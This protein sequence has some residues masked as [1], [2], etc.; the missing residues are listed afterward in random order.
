MELIANRP[1]VDVMLGRV[2]AGEVFT[3]PSPRKRRDLIARGIARAL[4]YE[5]KVIRPEVK[6]AAALPFRDVLA[7]DPEPPALAALVAAVRAVSDVPLDG[8]SGRVERGGCV[9]PN[10]S[11]GEI[12]EAVRE[13]RD[14]ID[15][16]RRMRSG[17]RRGSRSL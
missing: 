1:F 7:A 5:T 12:A 4:T 10:P 15:E 17:T 11:R 6:P 2:V 16:E 13:A 9:G 14:W 3:E 8:D